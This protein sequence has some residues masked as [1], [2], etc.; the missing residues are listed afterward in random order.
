MGRCLLDRRGNFW[1]CW[2]S[3][4]Y[5]YAIG[6]VMLVSAILFLI[7]RY[8][9]LGLTLLGPVLFNILVFHISMQPKTIGPG[10]ILTLLWLLVFWRHRAAFAGIFAARLSA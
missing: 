9:A 4:H 1:G 7:N 10:L 5:A 2:S 6:A 3:T 8:V